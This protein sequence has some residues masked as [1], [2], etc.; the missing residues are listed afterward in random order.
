MSVC[1]RKPRT[2][3]FLGNQ[4]EAGFTLIEL[5]VATALFCLLAV[6]MN[7][8]IVSTTQVVGSGRVNFEIRS[9]ARAALDLVTRDVGQAILR[10]DIS[11]TSNARFGIA[12]QDNHGN[13][14]LAFFTRRSGGIGQGESTADYRNL[15]FVSYSIGE[16]ANG[17]ELSFELWRGSVH[18][19]W[20]GQGSYPEV[21]S[22]HG[23]LPFSTNA[24]Q[25][26][27][28]VAKNADVLEPILAGVARMEIR[29]LG[30][31]GMYRK[32]FDPDPDSATRSKALSITLLLVDERTQRLILS[33]AAISA[34]FRGAFVE[35]TG[36]L[37]SVDSTKAL[38]LRWEEDL[39]KAATWNGIPDGM[40]AGIQ[41][42]GRVIPLNN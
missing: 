16:R 35:G 6:M 5:L 14:A 34:A 19:R 12:F 17:N 10:E 18:V 37:D 28:M 27:Y 3:S 24:F 11:A 29:F 22:S 42:F 30:K 21:E 39:G 26:S 1:I 8:V 7:Q 38:H 40:R 23:P 2:I 25:A 13:P 33:D 41:S 32:E 15:S 9:K 20:V 4:S 31:D 36:R